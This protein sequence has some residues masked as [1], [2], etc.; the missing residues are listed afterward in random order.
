[1]IFHLSES[2]PPLFCDCAIA[3]D[4][5]RHGTARS[6]RIMPSRDTFRPHRVNTVVT[7][8]RSP[9]V[10][11]LCSNASAQSERK[12]SSS[13]HYPLLPAYH[14]RDQ[15]KLGCVYPLLR[16]SECHC[17]QSAIIY[18]KTAC[19]CATYRSTHHACRATRNPGQVGISSLGLCFVPDRLRI[20]PANGRRRWA[21]RRR[22]GARSCR[23]RS[24][25]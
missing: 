3:G 2:L 12:T 25:P 19:R 9:F 14:R 20:K 10:K 13:P 15:P 8:S 1:V 22:S 18:S 24:G 16:Q 21:T 6:V 7:I 23:D 11:I 17:R 4:V 5:V